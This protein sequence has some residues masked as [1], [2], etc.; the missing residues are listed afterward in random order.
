MA[1]S[2]PAAAPP[3]EEVANL[4]LDDVTGERVSKTELKK[5]QKARQKEAAKAAKG[6]AAVPNKPKVPGEEELNPNQYH[7]IRTRQITELLKTNE[8]N[9]YPHKF[10][11][12]YDANNFIKEFSHLKS[13]ETLQDKPIRI[14]ARIFNKRAAGSKLIFYGM[15]TFYMILSS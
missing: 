11:V 6:P 2:N 15:G 13:G 9:P 3:T 7:E 12:D 5:R 1:D 14:A 8:P 10:H 4:H